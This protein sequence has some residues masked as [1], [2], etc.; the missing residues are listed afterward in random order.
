M[1]R[2]DQKINRLCTDGAFYLG[3]C[4]AE[5]QSLFFLGESFFYKII[6]H[7]LVHIMATVDGIIQSHKMSIRAIIGHKTGSESNHEFSDIISIKNKFL[8]ENLLQFGK[9]TDR[10]RCQ[11]EFCFQVYSIEQLHYSFSIFQDL[12]R[13]ERNDLEKWKKNNGAVRC[14]T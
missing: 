2:I 6:K 3:S 1:P 4:A 8:T 10:E 9:I 7:V 5:E 13:I 12:I 11:P 14:C